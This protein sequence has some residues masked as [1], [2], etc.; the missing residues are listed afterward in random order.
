MKRKAKRETK[1]II[2][3]GFIYVLVKGRPDYRNGSSNCNEPHFMGFQNWALQ[4]IVKMKREKKPCK[5][6]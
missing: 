5:N 1:D 6:K 4:A 2:C 3:N